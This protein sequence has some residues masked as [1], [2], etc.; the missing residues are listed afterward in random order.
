MIP[1]PVAMRLAPYAVILALSMGL[2]GT[3]NWGSGHKVARQAAE[4]ALVALRNAYVAATNEATNLKKEREHAIAEAIAT[5][6]D[7]ERQAALAN[8]VRLRAAVAVERR[9]AGRL[10]SQLADSLSRTCSAFEDP[11]AAGDAAA[12]ALGDVLAEALR[13]QAELAASSERHAGEVRALQRAWP[14]Q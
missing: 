11:A 4:T 10:R 8:E 2:W 5:A 1:L 7:L 6:R 3:Y 12:T 14:T 9:D 13:V